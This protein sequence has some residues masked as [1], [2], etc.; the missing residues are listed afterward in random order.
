MENIKEAYDIYDEI[1]GKIK[2]NRI[3]TTEVADVLGKT[4]EVWL[5]QPINRGFHKVG[6][7]HLTFAH[8]NS[9]WV[10]H[11]DIE[12]LQPDTILLVDL[13]DCDDRAPLGDIVAKYA[14][15]Y[16]GASAIVVNGKVRDAARLIKENWPIWSTGASPIGCVNTESDGHADVELDLEMAN[17]IAVCD[18]SGMIV[19]PKSKISEDFLI[20]LDQIEALEDAWYEC[21]DRRKLSTFQTICLRAYES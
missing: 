3:S 14:L 21:I 18:D 1:I 11:R 20:G 10:M 12:D 6:R 9:N 13:I 8:K 17:G 2:K 16:C 5:V 7:I 19:I 4:G 15:L